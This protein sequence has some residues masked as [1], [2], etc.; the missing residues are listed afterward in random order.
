MSLE[1]PIVDNRVILETLFARWRAP[2]MSVGLELGFYEVLNETPM[3]AAE[4]AKKLKLNERAMRAVLPVLVA[5]GILTVRDLRFGLTTAA[6]T[7]LLKDGHFF[8]GPKLM[9]Q[10]RSMSEHQELLKA[11]RHKDEYKG[12]S[13]RPVE[14]WEAGQIP[15]A[16]AK[17]IAAYMQS[18]CVGLAAGAAKSGVFK[19]VKK[20]LDVGGGSGVMSIAIAAHQKGTT[21]TVMDLPTMCVEADGYIKRAGLGDKVDTKAVDMF[22]QPWPKGYDGMVFSNIFHDWRFDTCAT[23]ASLAFKALKKGGKIF[24]HEMLLNDDQ[25]GPLATAGFSTQMLLGT[26]GQQFS[27][28]EL[29]KLLSDAGFKKIGVSHTFGYYSVVTGVKP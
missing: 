20:M 29:K 8:F 1:T 14:G 5:S 7:Y 4:L 25:S 26:Q 15:P 28:L 9:T 19:G 2:C 27:F 21:C 16:V 13:L 22:R 18:E 17:G 10:A 24:L 6:R 23:L 3:T 12:N 11:L